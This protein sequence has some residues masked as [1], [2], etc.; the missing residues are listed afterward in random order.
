MAKKTI[1]LNESKLSEIV[2][3]VTRQYLEERCLL[4]E[5]PYERNDYVVVVDSNARNAYIHL[6]KLLLYKNT[7]ND[8]NKWINDIINNFTLPMLTAKVYVSRKARSKVLLNGYIEN[9]FGKDL[10]DYD[11][12]MRNFCLSAIKDMEEKAKKNNLRI[13]AHDDIEQSLT[14]GKNVIVAYANAISELSNGVEQ[15]V[16][17]QKLQNVLRTEINNSFDLD[18]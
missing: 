14:A 13:P 10:E 7:T 11:Y 6:A 15:Q 3:N 4:T 2:E 12:Q 18:V 9:F 1:V 16:A 17:N 8:A 5:M